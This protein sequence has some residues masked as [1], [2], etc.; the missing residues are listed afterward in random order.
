MQITL[1]EGYQFGLGFFETIAIEENRPVFLTEHLERLNHS[2][3]EFHI[4]K[5]ISPEEISDYLGTGSFPHHALKLMVSAE[6]TLMTI[7]PNPYTDEQYKKG[8]LLDY[9]PV[10]RNETSPLVS[11]KSMNYGDCILEKRRA[12]SLGLNE[13]LFLNSKGQICEGT[14]SN[15][16]FVKKG[17]IYTPHSSCGLLPGVMRRYILEHYPVNECILTPA[18][19]DSMEECFVTNSLMGIMPVRQLAG[20]VF[21]NLSIFR[22]QNCEGIS[23]RAL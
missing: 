4:T 1:D 18:D 22:T 9:S 12:A 11:H 19:I 14:I 20:H 10:L 3:Q 13:L 21:D 5:T 6:N 17:Q 16:F 7:R 23:V 2:L 8:F 15:V